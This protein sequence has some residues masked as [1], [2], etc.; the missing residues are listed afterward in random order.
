MDFLECQWKEL[1]LKDLHCLI[2]RVE[3]P[4]VPSTPDQ[5]CPPVKSRVCVV[6]VCLEL[7]APYSEVLQS[8][9]VH[10]GKICCSE[11]LVAQ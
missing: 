11:R 6:S 5:K 3:A 10:L 1:Q 7:L 8:G 9:G 2:L 4:R